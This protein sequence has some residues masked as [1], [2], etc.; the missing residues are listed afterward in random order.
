MPL[1]GIMA[2]TPV[3]I[4]YNIGN[5]ANTIA[6]S[7]NNAIPSVVVESDKY[8]ELWF[9]GSRVWASL[10][11]VGISTST[12]YDLVTC[13]KPTFTYFENWFRTGK[14]PLSGDTMVARPNKY[15]PSNGWDICTSGV[16]FDLWLSGEDS[17][18]NELKRYPEYS[19]AH[20]RAA[21][22]FHYGLIVMP[23]TQ[24]W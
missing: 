8:P 18:V 2:A 10:Y 20:C 1:G 4:S 6:K 11:N 12:D 22:N 19:H 15:G 13:D 24:G 3:K 9:T 17:I 21:F 16:N 23:N 7:L 14:L 5:V